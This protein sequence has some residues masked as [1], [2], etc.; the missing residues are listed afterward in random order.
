MLAGSVEP[1]V[2]HPAAS[3]CDAQGREQFIRV[4]IVGRPFG[5]PTD[6]PHR[7][8]VRACGRPHFL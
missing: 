7:R 8:A 4:T 5:L 1:V 6:Y 2:R 3:L